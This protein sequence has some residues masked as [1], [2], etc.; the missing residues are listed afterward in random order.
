ME[1]LDGPAFTDGVGF[2]TDNTLDG[3]HRELAEY[4]GSSIPPEG[5]DPQ[6][7]ELRKISAS[8]ALML[9]CPRSFREVELLVSFPS[10]QIK[11]LDF[12]SPTSC[13]NPSGRFSF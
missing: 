4:N 12:F 5:K 3:P 7:F 8:Q 2:D 1:S 9:C 11:D 10:A 6:G 13:G